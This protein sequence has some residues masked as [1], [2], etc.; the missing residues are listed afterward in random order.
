MKETICLLSIWVGLA[1]ICASPTPLVESTPTPFDVSKIDFSQFSEVDMKATEEHRD[2]L[3][4][5]LKATLEQQASV[6]TDQS[7]TLADVKKANDETRKNFD[8]YRIV[9]EAQI[10]K[11]NKAI[12]VVEHLLKKLHLAKW[13]L[14][15][16]WLG[17]CGLVALKIP[18]IGLYVG[19]GLAI[20]GISYIWIWL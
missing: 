1:I 8:E 18:S 7:S 15:G 2:Q 5:K 20:A 14:C 12:V 16:V 13:I 6:V 3:K 11:G 9:S 10:A 4:K 17:F 19:G